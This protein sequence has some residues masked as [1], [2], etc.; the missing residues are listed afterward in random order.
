MR[1][2]FNASTDFSSIVFH[3]IPSRSLLSNYSKKDETFANDKS[4]LTP[5][6]QTIL[7]NGTIAFYTK[8]TRLTQDSAD[9][10]GDNVVKKLSN[11]SYTFWHITTASMSL[12]I[13]ATS[14][15]TEP[16]TC[17]FD[18]LSQSFIS[19]PSSEII[20]RLLSTTWNFKCSVMKDESS[21]EI[22]RSSLFG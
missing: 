4:I 1:G 15:L 18:Y 16:K 2:P 19:S 8:S 11:V 13:S 20:W 21:Y 12:S 7:I 3:N 10:L 14:N 22:I 9:N 17:S 6:S 5:F